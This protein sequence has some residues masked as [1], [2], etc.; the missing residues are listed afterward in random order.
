MFAQS[1]GYNSAK[2]L[3]YNDILTTHVRDELGISEINQAKPIQAAFAS[4]AS[5]SVKRLLSL[6]VTLFFPVETL[7]YFL[8]GF[9]LSFLIILGIIAA[10]TGESSVRK[11]VTIVT[12]WGFVAMA[13]AALVGYLFNVISC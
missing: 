3:S 11:A 4:G 13:M 8:Y 5:F 2:E 10:K 12:F 6:V 1:N 9:A 7:A